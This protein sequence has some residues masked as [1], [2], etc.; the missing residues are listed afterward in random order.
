MEMERWIGLR[1][2]QAK[3]EDFQGQI[4]KDHQQAI[5]EKIHL[6]EG[7][8]ICDRCNGEGSVDGGVYL[9]HKICSKCRG[10]GKVD[11]VDNILG[12]KRR[13]IK[14]TYYFTSDSSASMSFRIT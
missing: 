1:K 9:F 5:K 8:I 10:S 4:S 6:N 12:K 2:Q 3:N 13:K 7:E 11:W 14:G